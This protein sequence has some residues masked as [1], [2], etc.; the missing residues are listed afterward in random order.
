MEKA[1]KG[2]TKEAKNLQIAIN[3]QTAKINKAEKQTNDYTESLQELEKAGVKTKQEL[4]EL[5]DAQEKQGESAEGVA[6]RISKGIGGM[7]LGIAGMATAAVGSFMGMAEG[8]REFRKEQAQLET[9][10]IT[11]GHSAETANKM[12][13]EFNAV[14]GDTSKTT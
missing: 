2:N 12:Y 11:A 3:Q 8:T 7:A 4:K 14:L 1:G 5:T 10:F 9:A 13:A 6:S